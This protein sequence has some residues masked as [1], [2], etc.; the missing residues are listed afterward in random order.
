MTQWIE[1]IR[2]AELPE[3]SMRAINVGIVEV[4]LTLVD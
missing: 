2:L 1:A 3:G 4:L